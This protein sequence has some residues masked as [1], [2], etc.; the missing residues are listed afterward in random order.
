MG[1]DDRHTEP[2]L[3]LMLVAGA[4]AIA[5]LARFAGCAHQ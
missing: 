3:L 5:T 4:L 1:F 2:L